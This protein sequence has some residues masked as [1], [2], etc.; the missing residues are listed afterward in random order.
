M[1]ARRLLIVDD[2]A[3]LRE[4][5]RTL[6]AMQPSAPDVLE[7]GSWAEASRLLG[8]HP[9]VDWALLDLGLPDARGLEALTALRREHPHVRVVVLSASEERALVLECINRGAMGFIGKSAS[10]KELLDALSVLFAG[11]VYLPP[12]LFAP[13]QP[14]AEPP[15]VA[16]APVMAAKR[17]ELSR[18]G[19]T[20]RQI[21][22]LELLVQGLSNKLIAERLA[23]AEPTVKSHVAAG[24]RA[25][26][27]KNRTQAVFTLAR[28]EFAGRT[29]G[30]PPESHD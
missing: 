19:L 1:L 11:G 8:A 27:V 9:D 15:V 24:L 10:G 12:A 17:E 29:P 3:M 6:I 16:A 5:L 7:A 13:S 20:P 26:N 30:K 22:V 25:L 28:W 23:L 21:Q 2:H 4:G 18:L 14:A